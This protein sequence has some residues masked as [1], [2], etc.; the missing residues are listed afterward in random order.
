MDL[1]GYVTTEALT[2]ALSGYV[3]QVANKQL[4][5]EDF[6]ATF[7]SYLESLIAHNNNQGILAAFTSLKNAVDTL[8]SGNASDAIDSYNE[9]VAFLANFDDTETLAGVVSGINTAIAA[10]EAQIPT[11]PGA[12]TT[13]A[14][15]LMSAADKTYLDG[16]PTT[17]G[18]I[19]S[20]LDNING[21]VL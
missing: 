5:T 3:E 12:A 1:T 17:I 21:E 4:S 9:I 15:G 11:I 14:A 2:Q 7:K 13:T 6:T 20:I 10:V 16:L 8:V 19:N 18:N